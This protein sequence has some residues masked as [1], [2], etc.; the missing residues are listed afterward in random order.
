MLNLYQAKIINNLENIV[1]LKYITRFKSQHIQQV[2]R[3]SQ[4]SA[5]GLDKVKYKCNVTP[6]VN[7]FKMSY[8]YRTVNAWNLLPLNLRTLESIETFEAGLKIQ[9]WLILGFKLDQALD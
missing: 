1:L 6:S 2:K 7:S 9:L 8:F 3:S 4:A 5:E